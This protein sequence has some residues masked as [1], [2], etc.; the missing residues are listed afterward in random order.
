VAICTRWGVEVN[1]RTNVGESTRAK[2]VGRVRARRAE[3]EQVIFARVRDGAYSPAGGDDAEYMAGLRT[4]VVAAIDHGLD[5]V[6]RGEDAAGPAPPAAIAQAHRA[7][8]A[9]VSLDTVLRRYVLGST[10]LGDFLMQEAEAEDLAI[11]GLV[12]RE[13]LSTQAAVLDRLMTSITRE[14]TAELERTGRSPEQ[15]R[16]ERVLKLLAGTE[17]D[18]QAHAAEFRYEFERWHIGVIAIGARAAGALDHLASE[19]DCTPLSVAH[20]GD[21]VWGWLGGGRRLG[22]RELER[23]LGTAFRHVSLAVGEPA[24]GIGGWRLTHRQAQAALLVALRDP[25]PVTRYA[26]VALVASALVDDTLSTSLVDIYL[27]PLGARDNG[28]A[29][30][31]QTLRAYFAAER[32]ASSAA[33]ALGVSRHTVENRLRTIEDRLGRSLRTRQA[34]LEVAL[35]L[36]EIQTVAL[37]GVE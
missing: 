6:E 31:R 5:G 25:R 33:S 21:T 26:E 1:S 35:R 2:L 20:S 18:C 36:E 17:S 12:L 22:G 8:R 29:V 37:D 16:A 15:R 14:Y 24:R 10:I 30:L 19:L 7:A 27:A 28:G 23:A 34:E 3:L 13:V 32:N 4:A 11:Q 9:G